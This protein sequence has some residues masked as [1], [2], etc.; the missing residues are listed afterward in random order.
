MKQIY[1]TFNLNYLSTSGPEG[2]EPKY[3]SFIAVIDL[4]LRMYDNTPKKMF[5]VF[6]LQGNS[7]HI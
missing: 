2:P 7:Q 6:M 4:H 3:Y 5:Y 1:V